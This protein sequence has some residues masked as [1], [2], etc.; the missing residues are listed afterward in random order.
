MTLS[1]Q[2]KADY[3]KEKEKERNSAYDTCTRC[4]LEIHEQSWFTD[5]EAFH[6]CDKHCAEAHR[7]VVE[8][9]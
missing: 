3:E 2:S 1:W 7:E 8:S 9:D 5:E 6:F 4:G